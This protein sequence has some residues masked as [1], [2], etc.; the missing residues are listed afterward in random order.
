MLSVLPLI[1]MPTSIAPAQHAPYCDSGEVSANSERGN[2]R[3][4]QPRY[5]LG[6]IGVMMSKRPTARIKAR[7]RTTP[8]AP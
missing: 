8:R 5:T 6:R 2:D 7:I 4:L 1:I 3:K